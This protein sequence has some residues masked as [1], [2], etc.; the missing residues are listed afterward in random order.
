MPDA[1]IVATGSTA[2]ELP[3]ID[4]THERVWTSD[5]ALELIEMP[6][7]LLVVGGGVIGVEL[8]SAYAA[9]GATVALVELADHL[10]P[11]SDARS[12]RALTSALKKQGIEILVK[13]SVE[14]VE[15]TESGIVATLSDESRHEADILLSAVGRRP[16]VPTGLEEDR[17]LGYPYLIVGDA[18]G[19]IMLAHY[20][21]AQGEAAARLLTGTARLD[22][23]RLTVPIPHDVPA[24]VY[25]HPEIAS[26]GLSAEEAKKSAI[27]ARVGIAKFTANGRAL[28]EGDATGFVSLV[29]DASTDEILGAQIVGLH[30]V[31]LIATIGAAMK[32]HLRAE[33]LGEVV[34]AHPTV[35]EAIKIAAR[36]A[37]DTTRE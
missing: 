12:A 23:G 11:Q 8:A 6:R 15:Q 5:E 31:E 22:T 33:Q 10:L 35:S 30:A 32:G 3:V 28:A 19:G 21:E 37:S 1:L 14:R 18:A 2:S 20:A 16:I 9:F 29:I 27:A 24:C 34:F 13:T 7:R 4:Y 17:D 26:V 25:T 36:L